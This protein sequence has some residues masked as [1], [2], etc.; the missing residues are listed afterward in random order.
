[1]NSL[2]K[3]ERRNS[4][5]LLAAFCFASITVAP[6]FFIL[7]ELYAQTV[8]FRLA[9]LDKLASSERQQRLLEGAKNEGEA[10]VYANMDVAAMKP[11]IEG[12][13][14]R[15]S[16]LKANSVHFSGASIITR[17]DSESRAG[18]PLSDVV[19]SGQLGVL[20]LIEKRV[21]ARY[22]V[23]RAGILSRRIQRQRR[24]VDGLHDQRHGDRLQYAPGK[25]GRS[26]T[27]VGRPFEAALERKVDH[28]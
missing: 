16:G 26:S 25:K 5:W 10:V 15:Y 8:E 13:M 22:R 24:S 12:F 2:L 9:A 11:L 20:A 27:N 7:P 4:N 23:P 18:K 6:F 3:P 21:A 17:I 28:G 19:L 1:M 14:K